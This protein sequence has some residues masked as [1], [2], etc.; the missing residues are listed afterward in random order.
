MCDLARGLVA[1]GHEVDLYCASGSDVPGVR[2]IDTGIGIPPAER[3]KVFD[4]FYQVD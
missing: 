1:R 4:P 3:Q 2:V